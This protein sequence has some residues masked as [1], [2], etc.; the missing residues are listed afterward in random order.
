MA[1][2]LIVGQAPGPNTDPA[3]PLWPEPASSAGGRLASF[4]GLSP[5]EYL[6]KFERINLLN[7][8][9]GRRWKNAD[10][11]AVEPGRVAASAIRPLLRGRRVILLGRNVSEAFGLDAPFHV[12]VGVDGFNAA[13][14]P[15]PSGRSHW[16][17]DSRNSSVSRQFWL[18]LTG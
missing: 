4:A 8:F 11:W 16:Y 10:T 13:V 1:R 12:W 9:P 2:I 3:E 7:E 5:E 14:V 15:H 6:R 17:R 18:Q